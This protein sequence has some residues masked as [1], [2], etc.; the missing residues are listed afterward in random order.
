M[1]ESNNKQSV[2]GEKQPI[3]INIIIGGFKKNNNQLIE[4]NKYFSDIL[5]S[6]NGIHIE[7]ARIEE[8]K[9][10]EEKSKLEILQDELSINKYQINYLEDCINKLKISIIE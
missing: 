9:D 5:Y 6:F 8:T 1:S 3:S 7:K 2:S 4:L 10:S